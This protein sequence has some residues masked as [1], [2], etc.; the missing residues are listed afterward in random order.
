MG[1]YGWVLTRDFFIF[2]RS[3]RSKRIN[4][5][6]DRKSLIS[7]KIIVWYGGHHLLAGYSGKSR[8]D[9]ILPARV[10]DRI[11]KYMNAG[12]API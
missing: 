9:K 6:H 1:K 12:I 11:Y 3:K 7:K 4:S 8:A 5:P 2:S 10:V